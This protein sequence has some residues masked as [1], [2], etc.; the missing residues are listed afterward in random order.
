MKNI[1]FALTFKPEKQYIGCLLKI[2]E[3]AQPMST[4]QIS[5]ETGIP[6]GTSSGKVVPHIDYCKFMGLIDYERIDSNTYQLS[7]TPLGE[8]VLDEDP[9]IKEE[10]SLILLHSM[11]VRNIEVA[12]IWDEM[13]HKIFPKYHG[14]ISIE[15]AINELNI[16]YDNKVTKKNFAPFISSYE[17]MF[18]PINYITVENEILRVKYTP[19]IDKDFVYLYAYVLLS[20]W[21]E[22]YAERIEITADEFSELKYGNKLNFDLQTEYKVLE[23]LNEKGLIRL[24]RQLSPY[25]IMKTSNKDDLIKKL[26]SELF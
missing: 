18:S 23:L 24:N 10:L 13:Y 15:D 11:L 21:D 16:I 2:A 25:T 17:D 4:K 5:L 26:Y 3:R 20:Y 1:N 22:S 9:G 14:T 8:V 19:K 7:L 12:P 6:M